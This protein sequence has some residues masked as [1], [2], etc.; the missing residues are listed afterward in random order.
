MKPLC[1]FISLLFLISCRHVPDQKLPQ[2]EMK[3]EYEVENDTLH[4]EANNPIKCPVRLSAKSSLDSIQQL[5]QRDF[6]ITL[7]PGVDTVLFYPTTY[8]RDELKLR[9]S[10]D[11]GSPDDSVSLG[12]LELPFPNNRQY[13]IIQGYNGSFSHMYDY[14]R[15][16][17]DFSLEVGD[18]VCAAADGYVVGVVEG[19]KHG[20]N[21]RKWRDYANFIT[22]FHPEMNV[23]TQYV[24][25][26]HK[27]SLVVVG[28]SVRAG[29]TIGL[30]GK[31]GFTSV[32]HLHFNVLLPAEKG[33]K[34]TPCEFKEGYMGN[35]L[36]KGDWVKR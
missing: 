27:G 36:K 21:N 1:L 11:L 34:S 2:W 3:V 23:Y 16:A 28:D 9:F 25:L 18:T 15:F 6:P 29:Q 26:K 12:K 31:T 17:L 8:E 19:Y 35:E 32:E 20:G 7:R 10:A 4:I 33:M 14:S 13:K 5:L 30:S 22:I 24:H